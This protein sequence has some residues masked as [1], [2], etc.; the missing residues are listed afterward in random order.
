[1]DEIYGTEELIVHISAQQW[2]PYE[3]EFGLCKR[4]E[5]EETLASANVGEQETAL[6][7]LIPIS[8]SPH[9][10]ACVFEE[11]TCLPATRR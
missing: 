9:C 1:M 10:F 4:V 2:A 6:Q 3:P 5:D 8:D 11:R 7:A